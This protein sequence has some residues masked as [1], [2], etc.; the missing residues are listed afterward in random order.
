MPSTV[1]ARP[2]ATGRSTPRH[3]PRWE[4]PLTAAELEGV[5]AKVRAWQPLNLQAVYDDLDRVLGEHTP[6]AGEIA[7][8][9]ARLRSSLAQLVSIALAGPQDRLSPAIWQL[10]AH[11][12][13]LSDRTHQAP[14]GYGQALGLLRRTAWA[15]ADLIEHLTA[16][17]HISNPD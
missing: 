14:A 12:R 10:V 5:L 7:D 1:L 4:P 9:R 15:T 2:A 6:T 11:G 8:L 13:A 16:A 17:Q 3:A